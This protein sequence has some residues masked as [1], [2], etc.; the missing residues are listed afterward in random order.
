M[1]ANVA[2]HSKRVE[3]APVDRPVLE[4]WANAKRS[5]GVLR[6]ARGSC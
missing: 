2:A 5:S 1:E 3:I 4:K 6:I